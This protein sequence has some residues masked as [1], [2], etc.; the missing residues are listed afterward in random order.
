MSGVRFKFVAVIFTG[1]IFRNIKNMY[2]ICQKYFL[3]ILGDWP[4]KLN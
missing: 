2:C 3:V 1:N 4:K